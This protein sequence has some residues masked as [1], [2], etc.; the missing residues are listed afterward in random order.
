MRRTGFFSFCAGVAVGA[1]G[2]ANFPKLKESLGPL[3]AAAFAG[4]ES[5]FKDARA[6][7]ARTADAKVEPGHEAMAG[8]H[9]AASRSATGSSAHV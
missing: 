3:A 9:T 1:V 4:A 8:M 5:A 2:H 7:A 6:D